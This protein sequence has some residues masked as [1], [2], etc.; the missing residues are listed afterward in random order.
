MTLFISE[1]KSSDIHKEYFFSSV[2][3]F[4]SLSL[5]QYT[6]GLLIPQRRHVMLSQI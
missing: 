3:F 2:N 1:Y 6:A 5:S 4:L